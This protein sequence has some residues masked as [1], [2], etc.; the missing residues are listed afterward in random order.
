MKTAARQE[1]LLKFGV[2][3]PG[4]NYRW[5]HV[6]AV[7]KL[8]NKLSKL[9]GADPEIVEAAAWLH[10]IA[11]IKGERHP[12]VGAKLAKQVLGRTNFPPEKIKKVAQSI[13]DHQGLWLNKPLK[14][15]ESQV[16]WDADKLTK[17]GATA[18]MHQSGM[19]MVNG[20]FSDTEDLISSARQN[21]WMHR[22]VKSMHT[23]PARRAA[24]KRLK[25]YIKIW[26]A[27]EQEL[28]GD[29]LS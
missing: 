27:L 26:D 7:V 14:S 12:Q 5:E 4:F 29:D 25:R 24:K 8:A 15:L 6:K 20:K 18:A 11:K 10:D 28:E 2:P 23:K 3:S 16:L 19:L 17:I 9:T 13:A 22:T 21:N 1:A